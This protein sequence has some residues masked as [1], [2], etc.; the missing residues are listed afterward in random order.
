MTRQYRREAAKATEYRMTK[1]DWQAL[2]DL[3]RLARQ[4]CLY[5]VAS[6]RAGSAG[7]RTPEREK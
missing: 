7:S 4:V 5:G 2:Y 1:E 6:L 3:F